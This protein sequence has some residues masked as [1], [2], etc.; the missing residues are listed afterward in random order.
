M[1][2]FPK[3]SDFISTTGNAYNDE[4]SYNLT[5]IMAVVTGES[6]RWLKIMVHDHKCGDCKSLIFIQH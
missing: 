4:I 6:Q 3:V 2:S 1:D 5:I